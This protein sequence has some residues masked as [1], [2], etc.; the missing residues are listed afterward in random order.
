MH[1]SVLGP[2]YVI[3]GRVLILLFV[4]VSRGCLHLLDQCTAVNIWFLLTIFKQGA[5]DCVY[6]HLLH[7]E[8][9]LMTFGRLH[10]EWF[11]S[12]QHQCQNCYSTL[13]PLNTPNN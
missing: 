4:C 13:H 11:L 8:I 5:A 10:S 7:V 6:N 1:Y 2:L 9:L 12:N 3:A